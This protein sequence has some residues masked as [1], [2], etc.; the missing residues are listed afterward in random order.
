VSK[1]YCAFVIKWG[2]TT[3]EGGTHV[4]P[5]VRCDKVAHFPI[6]GDVWYCAQHWDMLEAMKEII[7]RNL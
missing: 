2:Y 3:E 7:Q 1:R 4:E 6:A 5:T